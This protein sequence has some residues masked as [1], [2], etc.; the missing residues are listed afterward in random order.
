MDSFSLFAKK[1]GRQL[2]T[3]V[4]VTVCV[5]VCVFVGSEAMLASISLSL[6]RVKPP[7]RMGPPASEDV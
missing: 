6:S 7:G 3:H 5:C 2:F 4:C 1:D